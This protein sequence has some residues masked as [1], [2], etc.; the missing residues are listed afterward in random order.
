MILLAGCLAVP[1]FGEPFYTRLATRIL[2][3]GLCAL[4]LDLILGFGGMVS[5]GHAAFLGMGAY[6]TGIFAFHGIF[7]A[8]IV[9]PVAVAATAAT[10]AIIGM[11]SLRTKGSY[12]IMI[13][14]AFAQM[15]FYFFSSLGTYGGDDG[16][17]LSSRSSMGVIDITHHT[18]FYYLVLAI[19]LIILFCV[20]RLTRSPFGTVIIG[21]RENERKMQAIG[22]PVFQYKLVCFIIAAAIAALAGVLLANHEKY[23][24][25]AMMH[26]TKSA[27][28][29]VMVILGGMGTLRGPILG[30]AVLLLAEEL[31]S[32]VTQHWMIFL[33]PLL[34]VMVLFAKGGVY[35]L[36][37][38]EKPLD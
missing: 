26:W 33:G 1:L 32:G 15:L 3:Y 7:S 23:I 5:L 2:I 24:S 37:P 30:A 6:L 14:L 17:A 16:M 34:I 31:L 9:W 4:S 22:Y 27:E 8:L 25:P 28:I 38:K 18:H 11:V 35:N 10:A 20:S 21:I 36:L 29:L 12:F 13:T 19:L